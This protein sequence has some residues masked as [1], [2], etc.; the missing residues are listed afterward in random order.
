M[1]VL[2]LALWMPCPVSPQL[3]VSQILKTMKKLIGFC[4]TCTVVIVLFWPSAPK[5]AR[6]SQVPSQVVS[7]EAAPTPTKAQEKIHFDNLQVKPQFET[8]TKTNQ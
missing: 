3:F 6:Q 5:V 8:I 2:R 4:A 7:N 1:L